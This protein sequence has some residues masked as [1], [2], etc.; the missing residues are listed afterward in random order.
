[1]EDNKFRFSYSAPTKTERQEIEDIRKDY[2]M[3]QDRKIKLEEIRD[4]DDRVKNMPMGISILVAVA[5]T[6]IF[7]LGLTFIL[8]WKVYVFGVI[9]SVIGSV[10]MGLTH[11]IYVK[12]KTKLT[13]KYK[14]RILKLSEEL[15]NEDE[16]KL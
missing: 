12:L 6:L 1:M 16:N 2:L 11:Y 15:L 7:G 14:D 13:E 4:L 10:T 3:P 5:G 8:E 9:V